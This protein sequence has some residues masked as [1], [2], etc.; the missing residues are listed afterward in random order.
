MK[1]HSPACFPSRNF[2]K[3]AETDPPHMRD[4]IIEQPHQTNNWNVWG[5]VQQE[6]AELYQ[7]LMW[8]KKINISWIRFWSYISEL[9]DLQNSD[10]T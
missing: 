7:F 1:Y 8:R 4:V 2:T 10:L 6:I 5:V 3:N 9:W